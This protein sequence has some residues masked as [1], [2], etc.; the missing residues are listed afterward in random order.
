MPRAPGPCTAP[1]TRPG[2]GA[3]PRA[4]Q[5]AQRLVDENAGDAAAHHHLMEIHYLRGDTSSALAA[6][7]NARQA[8]S[9]CGAEAA[10]GTTS[11]GIESLMDAVRRS[12]RPAPAQRPDPVLTRPPVLVGR[13]ALWAA[14]C[15]ALDQSKPVLLTGEAGIGKTRLLGDLAASLGGWPVVTACLGDADLPYAL[16]ARL[17]DQLAALHGAP[18]ADWVGVELS[19]LVPALH[20]PSVAEPFSVQQL[21]RALVEALRGWSGLPQGRLQGLAL[22]DLHFADLASLNLLVPVIGETAAASPGTGLAWL[23]AARPAEPAACKPARTRTSAARTAGRAPAPSQRCWLC[24]RASALSDCASRRSAAS[25]CPATRTTTACSSAPG[26]GSFSSRPAIRVA[27][28]RRIA[29][30]R[31]RPGNCAAARSARAASTGSGANNTWDSWIAAAR[32]STKASRDSCSA[33]S[34]KAGDSDVLARA[35]SKAGWC[36]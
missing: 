24:S 17:A 30:S 26:R 2:L 31:C 33:S 36:F 14:L 5:L 28:L 3:T 7:A 29:N 11:E 15:A 12:Q 19:R 6:Y 25:A 27:M 20:R 1:S 13:D 34:R 8:L 21:Q 10:S 16:L 23:M 35:R 18:V 9:T 4:L 32:I 22:D